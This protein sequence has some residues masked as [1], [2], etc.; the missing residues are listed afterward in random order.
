MQ[1]R[2]AGL[3]RPLQLPA[4]VGNV[5]GS[6]PRLRTEVERVPGRP[7]GSQDY[8]L[9]LSLRM[10]TRIFAIRLLS[11]GSVSLG[12]RIVSRISS[13]ACDSDSQLADA[14]QQ[15]KPHL[16]SPLLQVTAQ[17]ILAADLYRHLSVPLHG[18]KVGRKWFFVVARLDSIVKL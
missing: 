1:G 7:S 5:H 12:S 16:V 13:I 11:L 17:H 18:G 15:P 6:P 10:P 4:D 3:I 2:P 9:G 14:I 8:G